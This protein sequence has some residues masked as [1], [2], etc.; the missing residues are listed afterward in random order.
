MGYLPALAE[1]KR[2]LYER[3]MTARM[4]DLKSRLETFQTSDATEAAHLAR[5]T[6]LCESIADADPFSRSSFEP[7]HFTASAFV[8]S[9]ER[10]AL[11]LIFHGKLARWLQPGGHVDVLDRDILEAARREAREETGLADLT[12]EHEA[13]LGLDVHAIPPLRAEP[14]HLHFDVRFLFRAPTRAVAA[15]SDAKAARWVPLDAL[16]AE[17]TDASVMRAAERVR[18]WVR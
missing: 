7:G 11:L 4:R 6:A 16:D 3:A 17:L 13:P 9:P 15:A 12:L 8:L 14:A 1:W 5:M 2:A 10:D 18:A